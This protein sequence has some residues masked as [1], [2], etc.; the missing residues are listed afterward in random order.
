MKK[1]VQL[2]LRQ[3][4]IFQWGDLSIHGLQVFPG[5]HRLAIAGLWPLLLFVQL[6]LQGLQS[7][8][9]YHW[10]GVDIPQSL[11]FVWIT[12]LPTPKLCFQEQK[13]SKFRTQHKVLEHVSKP[14]PT[15]VKKI[16]GYQILRE[17]HRALCTSLT[18]SAQLRTL[19]A[20]HAWL[21]ASSILSQQ[22]CELLSSWKCHLPRQ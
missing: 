21:S 3:H 1:I 18:D 10:I 9:R 6:L 20:D 22:Y 5:L 7:T 19:F 12:Y 14:I 15:F 11:I 17:N 13:S 8:G 4:L 16:S 2:N